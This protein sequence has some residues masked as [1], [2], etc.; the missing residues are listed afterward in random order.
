MKAKCPKCKGAGRVVSVSVRNDVISFIMCVR[1]K[2][3]ACGHLFDVY[4]KGENL[5]EVIKSRYPPTPFVSEYFKR[6]FY[7]Y[8]KEIKMHSA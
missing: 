6:K 3:R 2:C 7:Q 4:E 5:M 8:T 1:R